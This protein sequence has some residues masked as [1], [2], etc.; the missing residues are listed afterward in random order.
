MRII[1]EWGA[2]SFA[3]SRYTLK[4]SRGTLVS[5]DIAQLVLQQSETQIALRS[6]V[7]SIDD[8]PK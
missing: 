8:G 1:H 3:A 5:E 2:E 7:H 4:R 6:L